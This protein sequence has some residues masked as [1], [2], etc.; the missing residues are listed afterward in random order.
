MQIRSFQ[1]HQ[2]LVFDINEENNFIQKFNHPL[3]RFF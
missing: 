2:I 3:L 1:G